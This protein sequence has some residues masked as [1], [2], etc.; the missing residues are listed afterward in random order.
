MHHVSEPD[1]PLVEALAY[2]LMASAILAFLL[3]FAT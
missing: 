1:H 3:I 2:V